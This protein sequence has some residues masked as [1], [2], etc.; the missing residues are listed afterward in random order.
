MIFPV[1]MVKYPYKTDP[2]KKADAAEDFVDNP[3]ADL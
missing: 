1:R 3:T 2:V